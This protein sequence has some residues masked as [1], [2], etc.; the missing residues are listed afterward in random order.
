MGFYNSRD[1]EMTR[2]F[3]ALWDALAY[4]AGAKYSAATVDVASA[5][6]MDERVRSTRPGRSAAHRPRLSSAPPRAQS[7][8]SG[9]PARPPSA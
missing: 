8:G 6:G 2:E 3:A 9:P 5:A 1:T 7:G 4:T